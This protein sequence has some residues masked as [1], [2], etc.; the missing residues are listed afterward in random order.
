MAAS[1][2]AKKRRLVTLLVFVLGAIYL[3]CP[4]PTH[5]VEVASRSSPDFDQ[6]PKDDA[7]V[8]AAGNGDL[9]T[10]QKLLDSG[11]DP[12]SDSTGEDGHSALASAAAGGHLP[13]VQLLLNRGADVN[14]EDSWGGTA[15]V[16]ASLWGHVDIVQL[17]L[18]HGAADSILSR[19]I[20]RVR[21]LVP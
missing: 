5:G 15:I 14:A 4:L 10:V 21:Y 1:P 9:N 20:L 16:G 6:R 2:K 13:I 12:N 11:V 8:I 18:A 17:L 7:F 19:P 3:F